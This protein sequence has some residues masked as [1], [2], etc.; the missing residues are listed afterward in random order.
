MTTILDK[1][2][3]TKK[4]EIL[5]TIV[6]ERRLTNRVKR[7]FINALT[8]S[9][10]PVGVIAEVKKA[11]PSK[12]I[13]KDNFNPVE[14]AV[15]YEQI[16]ADAISVLTDK[17]YFKGHNDYLTAIKE[18][19]DLPLLRKDFII[20]SIQVQESERIGADAILLIA[21]ILEPQK[22]AELYTEAR[23]L[24]LD[25]L[26]EVHDERELEKVLKVV[27]PELIGVNNR[28]LRTFETDLRVT[29]RLG[30]LIPSYT[31]LISE[32]GIHNHQ[33]IK[34]VMEAGAKGILA[35]ESFMLA[36]DKQLFINQL[37][38]GEAGQ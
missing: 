27:T 36:D 11:S 35:G 4:K 28:D 33:D 2:V 12:G 21:A 16:G 5:Q 9:D 20:D 14:I 1:I 30:Q 38:Y 24:G 8:G 6:P 32:S 18:S 25:V 13:I 10:H 7:S 26:I 23:E 15:T 3:E 34:R 17:T 37:I 22:L 19:V 29:E 31:A